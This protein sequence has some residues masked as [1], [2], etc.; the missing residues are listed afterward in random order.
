MIGRGMTSPTNAGSTA[1]PSLAEGT[2]IADKYRIDGVIGE[3]GMG[4]VLRATHLQLERVVAIKVVKPDVAQVDEIVARMMIEARAAASIKSEHVARVLDVA[5]LDDGTPY[6]VMEYLEGQDLFGVLGERVQLTVAETVDYVLQACEALAE[7]HATGIVH[8]DLKPENLFLHQTRDGSQIVKVLDFGI[9]KTTQAAQGRGGQMALTSAHG[10]VG[11]V[12][13]M[14]PEQMRARPDIDTRADIYALG[15]I[16]FELLTGR[17][18]FDGDSV[19]EVCAM[20]L[21]E[22][23]PPLGAVRPDVPPEVAAIVARCLEKDRE[24]RF[25]NVAELADEL[26]P[27]GTLQARRSAG[28]ISRVLLGK[29]SRIT[30][31]DGTLASAADGSGAFG[32][33]GT[34]RFVAAAASAADG[35]GGFEATRA[36]ARSELATQL[37]IPVHAERP[38][39]RRGLVV[40]LASS[41]GAATLVVLYLAYGRERSA[42]VRAPVEPAPSAAAVQTAPLPPPAPSASVA[43]TPSVTVADVVAPEASAAPPSAAAPDRHPALAPRPGVRP[44]KPKPS[45]DP[46][47]INAFGGRR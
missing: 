16:L 38:R 10:V 1:P 33:A 39:S 7:A 3:G 21:G 25:P 43:G 24:L 20:V 12:H 37:A 17:P 15:S 19:P 45:V 4:V 40:A 36:L 35:T 27:F 46:Y 13:Y 29:P 14:A 30:A 41:L 6:I 2:V 32:A 11:S 5:R 31:A 42:P 44:A 18:P 47:D 28:R 34:G 23:P 9:S 26:A 22:P 8:R